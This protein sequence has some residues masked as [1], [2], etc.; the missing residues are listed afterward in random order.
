MHRCYGQEDSLQKNL[1]EPIQRGTPQGDEKNERDAQTIID[2]L[3]V[4]RFGGQEGTIVYTS[5]DVST[6]M[7]DGEGGVQGI[8]S[9]TIENLRIP[10]SWFRIF[11]KWSLMTPIFFPKAN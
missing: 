3:K 1:Y 6:I 5:N 8:R 11:S 7:K 9:T 4:Y 2:T 10:N